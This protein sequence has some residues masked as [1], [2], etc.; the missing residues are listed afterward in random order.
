M[1][2]IKKLKTGGR[3]KYLGNCLKCKTLNTSRWYR[4]DNSAIC[5]N[6]YDLERR[7]DPKIRQKRILQ[8]SEW[9][10]TNPYRSAK[11]MAK[12]KKQIFDLTENE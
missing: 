8:R 6:C 4:R 11:N 10:K 2:I 7:T 3:K 1:N 5:K 9:E 12:H